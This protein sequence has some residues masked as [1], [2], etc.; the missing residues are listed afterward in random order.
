MAKLQVGDRNFHYEMVGKGHPL[1]LLAGYSCDHTIWMPIRDMLAEHFQLLLLDN[2]S[3]GQTSDAPAPFTVEDM[4][5]ETWEIIEKL[6][7]K[8]PHIIG[9]SMGG[10]IAQTIAY[11]H[12][13]KVSKIV[14][15]NSLIKTTPI[16]KAVLQYFFHLRMDGVHMAR[17]AEG[18][19]PWL[20]SNSFMA[21]QHAVAFVIDSFTKNPHPQTE[22]GQ[23]YQ[24]EAIHSFDSSSWFQ[25]IA[26]TLL[27]ICGEEDK[28]C[29]PKDLALLTKG[30]K[31]AK[32]VLI[33][34]MGHSFHLEM[35]MEFVK[36]VVDFLKG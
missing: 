2:S 8:N 31:N 30:M 5:K 23:R 32:F 4:A 9:H 34:E 29:P 21:N 18:I 27:V 12:P 22:I 7:L 33:P 36:L 13:E 3:V 28:L 19:L 35:P 10:A 11:K 24:L 17:I 1:V 20:F 14:I 25:K 15:A 6:G 26:K 16:C